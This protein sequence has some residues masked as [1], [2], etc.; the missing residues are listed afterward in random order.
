MPRENAISSLVEAIRGALGWIQD[1]PGSAPDR[2][3]HAAFDA[4]DELRKLLVECDSAISHLHHRGSWPLG[5]H[6]TD[7]L[8]G[9][10][11]RES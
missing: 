2:D 8:I 11:R 3:M 9:R 10:L 6:E 7:R 1:P 5:R 4:L